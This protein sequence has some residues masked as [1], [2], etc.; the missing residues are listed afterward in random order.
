MGLEED[1]MPCATVLCGTGFSEVV[2]EISQQQSA[3]S[4]S[5]VAKGSKLRARCSS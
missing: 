1:M 2:I 5:D 3:S 4:R